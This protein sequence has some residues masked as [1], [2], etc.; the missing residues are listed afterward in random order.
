MSGAKPKQIK[1]T[2]SGLNS[3][4]KEQLVAVVL[5]LNKRIA[6]VR[7]TSENVNAMLAE[8]EPDLEEVKTMLDRLMDSLSADVKEVSSIKP[9][10]VTVAETS[11]SG[12]RPQ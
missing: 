11:D 1:Y 3:L 5:E 6:S 8:A 2:Q 10:E 4:K 12:H 9:E 7:T